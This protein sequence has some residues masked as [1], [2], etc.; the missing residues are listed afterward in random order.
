MQRILLVLNLV[1]FLAVAY[2]LVDKFTAK[3]GGEDTLVEGMAEG[4]E[5]QG[6]LIAY[7]NVDTL[8]NNFNRFQDKQKTLSAREQEEDAKLRNRGRALER[9]IMALQ[10]KASTGTMTPKD[11]QLEEERLMRKQQEFL[12]DQERITRELMS[13]TTRIND[14]LQ[15]E[16]VRVIRE[17]QENSKYDYVLSYGTGSPVLAVN[18]RLDITA[19]VLKKLNT[20]DK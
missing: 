5:G 7:V 18:D 15:G 4:I 1:L 10:Q 11:L 12:A 14:E 3:G 13:E 16:I 8:L 9:E 19:Q 2:L 17:F 6:L 20:P